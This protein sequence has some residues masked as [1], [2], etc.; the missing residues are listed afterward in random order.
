MAKAKKRTFDLDVSAQPVLKQTRKPVSE[1]K[2]SETELWEKMT[3]G[4]E[5]EKKQNVVIRLIEFFTEN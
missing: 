2:H 5:R 1:K 3:Q 4:F